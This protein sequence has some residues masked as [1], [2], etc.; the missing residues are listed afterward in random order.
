MLSAAECRARA[1]EAIKK[2][3]TMADI[4]MAARSQEIARDWTAI[5]VMVDA[6]EVLLQNLV[7]KT[8]D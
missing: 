1:Q 2:A 5:A 3:D 4:V 6:L 8:L 7:A